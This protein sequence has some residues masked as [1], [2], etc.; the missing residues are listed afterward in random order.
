MSLRICGGGVWPATLT[1]FTPD[2]GIDAAALQAHIADVA[3]TRGVRAVVVNGH[4]GE[5]TSLDFAE[6]GRVV[7]LAA[8][9]S[10]GVPVVAGIVADDP[11]GACRLAREA[12]AA[13]AGGLLLFPPA[14]FAQGAAARPDMARRFVGEV[15]AASDLPI[16]L[17]QLS[18]TSGQAFSPALVQ[19]LCEEVPQIVGVKDGSDAPDLYEDVLAVLRG[20]P[21]PMAMLTSN[22]SWLMASLA[23]GGD[24]ILSGLGSVAAPLLV[25]LHEAMSAGDLAAARAANARLVPLCRVFYRAPYLDIHNRMKTA[26][27]LMGRLRHPAPRPPLLPLDD[28]ET[29]RIHAA[30]AA[31]GLLPA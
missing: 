6:R 7:A 3:G 9:A 26:L 18:R 19:R 14:L 10:G 8:E 2:G 31:A 16:V 27:K 22:N 1:P 17:F 12:A 21:R 15:A 20:L 13:G 25:A 29:T 4:A 30:L 11:R 28:A 23:Y 24:G 5:T